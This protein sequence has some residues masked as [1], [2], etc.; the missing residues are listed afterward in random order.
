MFKKEDFVRFIHNL[1]DE[2]CDTLEK[3]D[4]KARFKEDAWQREDGGGGKTRIIT[5]GLVFEKGGVN[6]SVVH[7]ELPEVMQK[8]LGVSQSNFFACGISLVLHPFSPM[9]PTVHANFRYFELYD[10]GKIVD[11]WFGGGADL[12]PYYVFVEDA[13]HFHKTFKAAC[14]PFGETLYADYKL[15]CDNYFRNTHRNNEARGIGGIFYDYLRPHAARTADD[16]FRFAQSCGNAFLKAY[17]PIVKKR[18]TM[19][20]DENHKKWQ[21]LRRGRY[22]EFNLIH[23]KGTLFGLKTNGRIES[24]LMSLPPMVAWEYDFQPLPDSQEAETLRYLTP[25]NWVNMAETALS[26]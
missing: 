23:D 25:Q 2:I 24:I 10:K 20:F 22:V 8:Q 15:K 26:M 12:T 14:D 16:L 18:K 3:I 7:G 19:L 11:A 21:C 4:G 1:Q 13:A 9:I 17:V 6:T 5:G